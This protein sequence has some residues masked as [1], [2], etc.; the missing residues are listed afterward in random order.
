MSCMA[1]AYGLHHIDG[2]HDVGTE[3]AIAIGA[4]VVR[5]VVRNFLLAV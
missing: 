5:V 3:A 1:L 2:L 4:D